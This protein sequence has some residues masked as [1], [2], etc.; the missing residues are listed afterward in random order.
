MIYNVFFYITH[1]LTKHDENQITKLAEI[2]KAKNSTNYFFILLDSTN[3]DYEETQERIHEL[4]IGSNVFLLN[5]GFITRQLEPLGY[6][7]E[8]YEGN[9]PLF[10]GNCMLMVM[11][12]YQ[13]LQFAHIDYFWIIEHDVYFNGD[14]SKLV[15][16]YDNTK[17]IDFV[18]NNIKKYDPTWWHANQYNFVEDIDKK[19]FRTSFNPIM[20]ISDKGMKVLDKSYK[21]GNSGFYELYIQTMFDYKGLTSSQF[22]TFGFADNNTFTYMKGRSFTKDDMTEEN[23]LYHP[24]K[25]YD[26]YQDEQK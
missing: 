22:K 25:N 17:N 2:H 12:M 14:W 15:D 9:N 24:V 13:T 11:Y 8:K 26:W 4:K 19:Y 23:K 5:E 7:I 3:L 6:V 18:T 16:F 20:R 1:H 10:Y 21:K